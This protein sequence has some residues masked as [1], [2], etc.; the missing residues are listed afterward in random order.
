MI[1]TE[2]RDGSQI[3]INQLF[4]SKSIINTLEPGV[5]RIREKRYP[6]SKA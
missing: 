5:H 6:V 1:N 2:L 3:N 4:E